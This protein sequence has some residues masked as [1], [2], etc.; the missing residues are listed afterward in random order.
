MASLPSGASARTPVKHL[1][2]DVQA[3]STISYDVV[4]LHQP[5]S[6]RRQ[7]WIPCISTNPRRAA[8]SHGRQNC[9]V[10][11]S[12]ATADRVCGWGYQSTIPRRVIEIGEGWCAV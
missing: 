11:F 2:V 7:P 6:R 10:F 1:K 12:S 9:I 4:Y 8:V 3:R 5:M